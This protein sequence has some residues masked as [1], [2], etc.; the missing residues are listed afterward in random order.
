M[1]CPMDTQRL[2]K[3]IVDGADANCKMDG[4]DGVWVEE[5]RQ[6]A[7]VPSPVVPYPRRHHRRGGQID[8]KRRRRMTNIAKA[9]TSAYAGGKTLRDAEPRKLLAGREGRSGRRRLR[10]VHG[11]IAMA[12][13]CVWRNGRRISRKPSLNGVAS[14]DKWRERHSGSRWRCFAYV[15]GDR[16]RCH[17]G[18]AMAWAV[19][20]GR[21]RKR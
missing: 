2:W 20:C 16:T 7:V 13:T 3:R 10:A 21:K 11:A 1:C 4:E 14:G 12:G 8:E 18:K 15:D 17:A 9:T 19:N 6:R 5:E